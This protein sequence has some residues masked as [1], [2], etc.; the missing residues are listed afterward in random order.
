MK[1]F[2]LFFACSLG[3]SHA[4]E[5]YAQTAIVNV[6]VQN[7]TVGEILKEIEN[8]SEFDFFFDN[9][10]ID[11]NRRVSVASRNSD[12][13]KVL[14]K[15]F[16]GTNVKY[17]VLDKKIVLTTQ[18]D[19]VQTAQQTTFKV[20]GKVVD[21]T[22]EGVIGATVLEQ[23]TTNGTVTDMDGNFELLV[24]NKEVT[25]EIS[26]IGFTKSLVKV[27]SGVAAQVALKE[28][29]EV[30]DEVVVVGYGT[31]KKANLTGAVSQVSMD[32]VL[33]NRPVANV[34]AA[35]QGA[36]P[37]LVVTPKAAPGENT[38]FNI[39]GTTSINGGGPLVLIDNV[40]G[41]V[42]LLNPED[43]ESVS[44]LK[45]AASAAVYGARSAFGVVLITTKKAKKG[46]KM[47]INYNNT[48]GWTTSI[49]RPEQESMDTYFDMWQ[50][51]FGDTHYIQSMDIDRWRELYHLY[52]NGQLQGVEPGGRYMDEGGRPY[53]LGNT[54]HTAASLSTGFQQ[55]HNVSAS[56]GTEKLT[57]RLSLGYLNNNGVQKGSKDVYERLNVSSYVS[58]DI[59]DWLTTSFDFRYTKGDRDMPNAGG[60]NF[61][62]V[63][64]PN[65][66]PTGTMVDDEGKTQYWDNP[67]NLLKLAAVNNTVTKNP[68]IY[69]R[70]SIHPIEGLEMILEYTYDGKEVASHTYNGYYSLMHPQNT[71]ISDPKTSN[72]GNNRTSV[73]YNSINAYATY[74]KSFKDHNLKIMGGFSQE[75][76]RTE[77]LK[78][79]RLDMIDPDLPSIT[80]GVGETTAN[81][82]YGEYIIRGAYGRINY[83]YQGKYLLEVNGRYDGSSRF[84]RN[85]RYGFFPSFSLG[86]QVGREKFMKWTE[87]WLNEFKLRASWGEIGNQVLGDKLIHNYAYIAMMDPE[88][89]QWIMNGM[90]PITLTTPGMVSSNFTWEVAKTTNIGVDLSLFNNR[91][92]TT[93]EWYQRRTEGMLAPGADFSAEIGAAAPRMNAAD[94]RN[95]GW[96]WSISWREQKGD[97]RYN[98]S[99][100]I[101]DSKTIIEKYDNAA[102]SLP[103]NA[104][105]YYEGMTLGERWGYVTDGFYEID[106]FVPSS[107]DVKGWQDGVWTLREGVTSIQGTTV[108]PGDVK[109]KN[110]RDDENSVNRIDPG[111]STVDNPGDQKII[112]NTS[113]RF[114]FGSSLGFGYKGFDFSMLLQGT[115][116]RDVLLLDQ[117]IYKPFGGVKHGALYKG[118]SDYWRPSDINA[119][120]IEGWTPVNNNP[121]Y[122][123]IYDNQG[124]QGSNF[125]A[126]THFLENGA[127]LRVKNITVGY[128]FPTAWVAK[129]G[130]TKAKVYFS[131][132]NLFT[133]SSLPTGFDPERLSWSYPFYRTLS[134]GFNL[135]L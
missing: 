27:K 127:Y 74:R 92:Q 81:D 45:D 10:L 101:Y 54:D 28:D 84:P 41:D 50:H 113:A 104:M 58:A 25:L 51:A 43:I 73:D 33:G 125:R 47:T 77:E 88:K 100:N 60:W 68:R 115:G 85:N 1:L 32:K 37:G 72:F 19:N 134:F 34:G 117:S 94:L 4:S 15:V 75:T 2:T 96:E 112:G 40:P 62:G 71:S 55:T 6:E 12:I 9:T 17:S 106:D 121:K 89:A 99:F 21:N 18:A 119:N 31:Q 79:N 39:R 105:P 14:E 23:G 11:L 93:F 63:N 97:W 5:S 102:Y 78:V 90:R 124:N 98:A 59:T 130:L 128:T 57:Y 76:S 95:R 61:F 122:P 49:G 126:Q 66:F 123:R 120:T 132:E 38:G 53:F 87:N 29:T 30:L 118:H 35:L 135:T 20:T 103:S 65:Y 24:S 8:Q 131:G 110:L 70:T 109:F 3:L 42:N 80:G 86:W 69:S 116:K 13:F 44:V 22:G 56:G 36:I 16:K 26:Y 83:D 46:E 64:C 67:E 52:H 107:D 129:V 48:L 7:R 114:Q 91:L 108:R 111:T 133:F 82:Y